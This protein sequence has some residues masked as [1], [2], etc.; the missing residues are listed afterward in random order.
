MGYRKYSFGRILLL[1]LRQTCRSIYENITI[2]EWVHSLI[3]LNCND[4][5]NLALLFR[6]VDHRIVNSNG[7]ITEP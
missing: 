1:G 4:C 6:N 7:R 5:S 3:S 2:E